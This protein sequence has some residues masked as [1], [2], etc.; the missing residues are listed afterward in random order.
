M[1]PVGVRVEVRVE[2]LPVLEQAVVVRKPDEDGGVPG[3]VVEVDVVADVR[4]ELLV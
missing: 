2:V 3:E 1:H 4:R